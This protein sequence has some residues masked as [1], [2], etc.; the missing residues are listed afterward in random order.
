MEV[1]PDVGLPDKQ[2]FTTLLALS[3]GEH[4]RQFDATR[5]GYGLWRVK[6]MFVRNRIVLLIGD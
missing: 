6:G 4:H 2:V 5:I 3:F 1:L